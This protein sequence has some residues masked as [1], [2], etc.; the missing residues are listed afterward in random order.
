M[1]VAETRRHG[2]AVK[3]KFFFHRVS[4]SL[5]RSLYLTQSAAPTLEACS[6]VQ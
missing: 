2:D 1:H 4:P 6:S 5:S 3:E